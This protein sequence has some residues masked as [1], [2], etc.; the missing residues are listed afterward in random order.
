MALRAIY[1]QC[2][3]GIIDKITARRYRRSWSQG[4]LSAL[5]EEKKCTDEL[6][7]NQ[8]NSA[9]DSYSHIQLTYTEPI[10]SI[11]MGMGNGAKYADAI[12]V[13]FLGEFRAVSTLY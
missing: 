7:I 3:E 5:K 1:A 6:L 12:R 8:D 2:F 13:D 4:L 9:Q 11:H 10:P